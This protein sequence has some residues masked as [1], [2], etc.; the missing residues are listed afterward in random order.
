MAI[1]VLM[2]LIEFPKD[3]GGW[4]KIPGGLGPE[5]LEKARKGVY[6]KQIDPSFCTHEHAARYQ[7]RLQ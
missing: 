1:M 5:E 3:I 4:G 7:F 6:E 2:R